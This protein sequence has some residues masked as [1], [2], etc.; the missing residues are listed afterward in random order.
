MAKQRS[1]N[2]PAEPFSRALER[3]K[4]IYN[5][6]RQAAASGEVVAQHLGYSGLN[7][8]SRRVISVLKDFGLLVPTGDGFKVSDKAVDIL[9]LPQEDPTHQEALKALAFHPRIFK[10]L[11]EQHGSQLPSEAN[12]VHKM[13]RQGF[14]EMAAK[15]V[16]KNY[17]ETIAF[18]DEATND[19]LSEGEQEDELS[20]PTSGHELAVPGRELTAQHKASQP[21]RSGVPGANQA[22]QKPLTTLTESAIH[23]ARASETVEVR[24]SPSCKVH[25]Q[26]EGPVTQEAIEKLIR[27]LEWGKDTYPSMNDISNEDFVE[28]KDKF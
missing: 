12:L 23:G 26:Y 18:V 15:E 24:L 19:N 25:L 14:T 8:K 11:R 16:I 9:L 28:A 27:F 10:Q 5:K 4:E 7:G 17:R 22:V 2:Y 6:E 21:T 3:V 20:D 1:P 13:V